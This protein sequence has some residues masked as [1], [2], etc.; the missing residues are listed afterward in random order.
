MFVTIRP[1]IEEIRARVDQALG[2]FET[3]EPEE[4]AYICKC[5]LQSLLR[6]LDLAGRAKDLPVLGITE[7]GGKIRLEGPISDFKVTDKTNVDV[8]PS[9]ELPEAFKEENW[10]WCGG[11]T[12]RCK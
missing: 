6:Y 9:I 8:A 7:V 2:A 3:L 1:S 12:F 10:V 11:T 4:A 5:T